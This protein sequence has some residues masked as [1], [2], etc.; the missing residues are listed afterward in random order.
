MKQI[1]KEV[2]SQ[3]YTYQMAYNNISPGGYERFDTL[4][5]L[6]CCTI[7][8]MLR[9]RNRPFTMSDF[10]INWGTEERE[11]VSWK[12]LKTKLKQWAIMHNRKIERAK[13]LKGE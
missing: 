5:S 2:D 10:K 6:L 12:G 7:A 8:N 4:V 9:S 11:S 1:M 3:E 13:K